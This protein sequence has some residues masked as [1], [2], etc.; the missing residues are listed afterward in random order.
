MKRRYKFLI[1][2]L[3]VLFIIGAVAYTKKHTKEEDLKR[4]NG[5][6]DT[7]KLLERMNKGEN[8]YEKR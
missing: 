3:I 8:D 7:E 5:Y 4:Q 6:I 2:Y 1:V